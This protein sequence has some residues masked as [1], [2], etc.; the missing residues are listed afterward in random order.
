M[1]FHAKSN[2]I[3]NFNGTHGQFGS[4]KSAGDAFT[5]VKNAQSICKNLMMNG[6]ERDVEGDF[7]PEDVRIQHLL[8]KS[9]AEFI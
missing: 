4:T 7:M 2:F 3:G 6:D 8:K 5:I 1:F 9:Y